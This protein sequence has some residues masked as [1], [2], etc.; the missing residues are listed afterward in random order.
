MS[1]VTLT[2]KWIERASDWANPILVKETRQSLKSRQFVVTFMLLLIASWLIS[3]FG[4][5]NAGDAIEY[6]STGR[7]FFSL[8]YAVLATAIFVVVPFGAYRSLLT[9][10][11]QNTF[12][13]LSITT[14]SPRQ[15]VWGK[16]FSALVQVFIFYSA[17]APFIAFTSLLQGFDLAMVAFVL[18]SSLLLSLCC[19]MVALMLSTITRQR[20]WQALMSLGVLG[21]LVWL[22]MAIFFS[23]GLMAAQVFQFDDPDFWWGVGFT[24]AGGGSYLVLAQ[25]IT[26]AQLTFES[27]NRSTGIRITCSAQF[28]MLWAA[29]FVYVYFQGGLSSLSYHDVVPLA[30]FAAAHCLLIGL[31]ATSEDDFLS[32][33]IRRNLP[34]S[35]ML[36]CLLVPVMPG[37]GRGMIYLILH[38]ATLWLLSVGTLIFAGKSIDKTLE[39]VTAFCFYLVIYLGFGAALGRWARVL[40]SEIR[41]AHTRVL[42]IL[43]AAAG[44]IGPY[45]PSALNITD[46]R[47]G[48]SLIYVTNPFE[49]F[50]EID[51]SGSY[52][53][54]VLVLLGMATIVSLG[55][56]LRPML[57]G[58]AEIIDA[59]IPAEAPKPDLLQL[60]F[61]NVTDD[62]E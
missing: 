59:H 22:L 62:A 27:G 18:V 17:I 38:L 47:R 16:L 34:N 20:H 1:T 31:F 52:T 30:G 43:L 4:M 48:Y 45:L 44:M 57:R 10:R 41:S 9:E 14:L 11:D 50:N 19:S 61:K 28:F 23:M 37:G 12:E 60:Q 36:R 6:G 56:N 58:I 39:M 51:R 40:S 29:F 25:Q 15:I 24:M 42:T 13:L 55:L 26:T 3:V 5:L 21:G 35:R 49:T 8:Y 46:W 7:M 54:E 53:T 33:R 2:D 32:R